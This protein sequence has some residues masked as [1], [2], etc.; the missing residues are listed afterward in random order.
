MVLKSFPATADQCLSQAERGR[1]TDAKGVAACTRHGLS[2]FP[3]SP[4][5]RHQANLFPHLGRKV[6]CAELEPIHG[7]IAPTPSKSNPAHMTWWSYEGVDRHVLFTD[8]EEA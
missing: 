2:V 3:S 7:V 8:V 1:V 4:A 5:C 6:G